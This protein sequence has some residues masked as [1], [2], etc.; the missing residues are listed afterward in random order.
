MS[1]ADDTALVFSGKSR[2]EVYEHA[3]SGFNVVS[4]WLHNNLLTLN[5][6]KTNYMLFTMRN[7]NI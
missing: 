6:H 7:T 3:Q 4:N 5:S 1:Y 2:D